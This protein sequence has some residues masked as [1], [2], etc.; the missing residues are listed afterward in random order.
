MKAKKWFLCISI[1][2]LMGSSFAFGSSPVIDGLMFHI[3]ASEITGLNDGDALTE[4]PATAGDDP[5]IKGSP[6]P[7]YVAD[8]GNGTPAVSF[9]GGDSYLKF[10]RMTNIRTVFWV[11][12]ESDNP[13]NTLGFLLG[14]GSVYHFHRADP[15]TALFNSNTH[16]NITNGITKLNGHTIDGTRVNAPTDL[17]VLSLRTTGDVIAESFSKDRSEMQRGWDGQ[18]AELLIY[19][20]E[21]T[22]K[23]E[24]LV[25][26][27]LSEKYGL[28]TSYTNPGTFVQNLAPEDGSIA[29]DLNE[30]ELSWAGYG[31]SDPVYKLYY[32]TDSD[33]N[34]GTMVEVAGTSQTITLAVGQQYWWHVSMTGGGTTIW[35]PVSTFTADG[36]VDSPAPADGPYLASPETALSWRAIDADGVSYDVYFGTDEN[37]QKIATVSEATYTPDPVLDPNTAYYWR[38]DTVQNGTTI[39]GDVWSFTTGYLA[40]YWTFDGDLTSSIPDTVSCTRTADH[41]AEGFIGEG[42]AIEFLNSSDAEIANPAKFSTD[43]FDPAGSWSFSFWEYSYDTGGGWETILG[44]GSDSG[45]EE[46][47]FGRYNSNRYVLGVNNS[48]YAATANDSSYLREGWHCHVISYDAP[49]ETVAWYINGYQVLAYEGEVMDLGDNYVYIGN[50]KNNSQPF[51]GKVDDFKVYNYP[52]TSDQV[53]QAYIDGVNGAPIN[54]KPVSGTTGVAWDVTLEW[55]F[56]EEPIAVSIE[57]GTQADLSDATPIALAAD[58]TSFDVTTAL[59]NLATSTGYFWRVTATYS[60]K[61]VSGPIW[62]FVVRDL[63]GDLND[64]LSVNMVDFGQIADKWMD[65]SHVIVQSG[66]KFNFIDQEAW[67]TTG[68][69]PN[70]ANYDAYVAPSVDWG[71]SEM[72]INTDPTP[73]D[74]NYTPPS[75]TL[76]WRTTQGDPGQQQLAGIVFLDN[77]DF[78]QFDK[79]GVWVYQRDCDG[80]MEYRP[81]DMDNNRPFTQTL[82]G[83]G[84]NNDQWHNYEWDINAEA[85]SNIRKIDLWVGDN[86]FSIEFGNFYLLKEGEDVEMCLV[87]NVIIEDLNSDCQVDITD[88]EIIV[89]NW[90]LD[91]SNPQ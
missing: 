51:I 40:D 79:F 80:N 62:Y 22:S 18:L 89:Q 76:V 71:A 87:E 2:C 69:D 5:T 90:L 1:L 21:L 43:D 77:Y 16:E 55:S 82:W 12:K 23:E 20:R 91:A 70:L 56:A 7:T 28:T 88:F 4:W 78:N 59:G 48:S 85:E 44:C 74:D 64:D 54:P 3:D 47:E 57:L 45:Y 50:V 46:F 13:A 66:T 8:S 37:P 86:E 84:S 52:L 31:V 35:T 25:G 30:T 29:Y 15:P 63:E 67:D 68:G 9:V 36:K 83:F 49:T 42:Q 10:T 33:P 65:D 32:D 11:I 6:T 72:V 81:L 19:N 58:A 39:T 38:I 24:A 14:D 53:L 26:Y 34:N 61:T 41:F 27:Y 75:Q 17:S 60:D 73:G